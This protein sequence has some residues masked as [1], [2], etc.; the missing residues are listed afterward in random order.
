M[1]GD[2]VYCRLPPASVLQELDWPVNCEE[3][4]ELLT[5]NDMLTG[6]DVLA[7]HDIDLDE[8]VPFRCPLC[9]HLHVATMS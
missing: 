4:D 1:R 2:V 5:G 8:E 9:E 6:P 3:C 7:E